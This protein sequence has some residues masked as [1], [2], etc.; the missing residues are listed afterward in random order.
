MSRTGYKVLLVPM[1]NGKAA[2]EYQD[3]PTGFIFEAGNW[4][5]WAGGNTGFAGAACSLSAAML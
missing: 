1:K 5:A 2:G 3:F 4:G